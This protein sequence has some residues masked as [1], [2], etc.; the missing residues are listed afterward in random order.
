MGLIEPYKITLDFNTNKIKVLILKQYDKKSRYAVITCTSNNSPVKLDKNLYICNVKAIVPDNRPIYN[1]AEIQ[2]DGTILVEFTE[3]ML[4]KS[5]RGY[6][7]LNIIS[8]DSESLL[9]TMKLELKIESSVY[10]NDRVVASEEFD[11]LT[12]AITENTVQ[13]G[14]LEALET[15]IEEA[16]KKRTENENGRIVAEEKREKDCAEAISKTNDAITEANELI[17]SATGAL[18]IVKQKAS[19]V[20]SN[21]ENVAASEENAKKYATNAEN[22]ATIAS[23]KATEASNSA[24]SAESYAV[25]DTNSSKYYYE[26]VKNVSESLSGALRPLGTV[27]FEELP[28]LESVSSGDMYNVSDEFTTTDKFKEG[29]GNIVPTGANVYKTSDGHWDV[30]AGTPVTG[31]KGDNETSYRRGNVNIT[32]KDIGVVSSDGGVYTGEVTF[33]DALCSEKVEGTGISKIVIL[34]RVPY[35]L[36]D[37]THTTDIYLKELLKWICKN[38]PNKQGYTFVGDVNPSSTTF[39]QIRIYNTSEVDENGYPKYAT[40]ICPMMLGVVHSFGFNNYVFYFRTLLTGD[41]IV[42]NNTTTV[43]G[44][45][46]DARQANPNVSGSLAKQVSEKAP[47]NHASTDT[48]YGTGNSSKFGHVKLSDTYTSLIGTAENSVGGS[49]SALYNAYRTLNNKFNNYLPLSGGTLTSSLDLASGKYIHG[50]L[51]NGTVLDVIGLNSNNNL[52]IGNETTPT[53]IHGSGYQLDISGAYICPN[54]SN[55][56]SCGKSDKLFTTIYA[57]T[58]TINTSDRTKKHNISDLT[59]IYEK[60]FL[61][62]QPKSFVFND[63]DRVHIGAIS[64]DVEDIMTE[65]GIESKQ[66]AGFCKDIRYKY[67]EFSEE[68]GTPIESSKVPCK[69][70][71]G[72]IIYDYALRYQEFIFLTIHMVQRLWKRV[73]IVEKENKKL[74]NTINNF[75]TR[76]A[77]LE[78]KTSEYDSE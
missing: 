3:T 44:Y 74:T 50:T 21:A 76:L 42:N 33:E 45:L 73:D 28:A 14:K 67:T 58:G 49:Q 37:L 6:L 41:N 71:N 66:F 61:K 69:D 2:D 36:V 39:A 32:A 64:Q 23:D 13:A 60:F 15:N 24:S 72:N 27:T 16:E 11:A 38:Y 22:S 77:K 19:E 31:I 48:T 5:G 65:L 62:L 43:A 17:L 9:S 55:K 1:T 10:D 70:K 68:D 53:Y 52:H 34:P 75:E 46:L 51:T 18:E 12:K 56:M 63:G 25:G 40:G 78:L 59:E 26:Q 54:V 57:K 4:V 20:E 29:S 35:N 8:K 7:E 30:L 47:T